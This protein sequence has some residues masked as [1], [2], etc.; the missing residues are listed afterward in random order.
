MV[1]T[2]TA[3]TMSTSGRRPSPAILALATMYKNVHF[4]QRDRP[5]VLEAFIRAT[6]SDGPCPDRAI[7]SQAFI[8]SFFLTM[9]ALRVAHATNMRRPSS[10]FRSDF[11]IRFLMPPLPS[12]RWTWR[13]Y[14]PQGQA[15]FPPK[16]QV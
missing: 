4:A 14:H 9:M 11:C 13:T 12:V 2:M 6:I 3:T 10:V 15:R 5:V 16:A 1:D 8:S 7:F